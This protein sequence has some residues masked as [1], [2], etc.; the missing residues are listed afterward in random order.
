M[1]KKLSQFVCFFLL[2]GLFCTLHTAQAQTGRAEIT[3]EISDP[4]GAHISAAE[5]L[6]TD[7]NNSQA[8]TVSANAE[9]LLLRL[10]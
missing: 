8:I 10:I 4:N 6:L 7:I 3:G 2:V 1:H 5:I 9:G